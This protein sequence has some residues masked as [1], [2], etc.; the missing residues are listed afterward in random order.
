MVILLHCS[1]LLILETYFKII[2]ERSEINNIF[3]LVGHRH[4]TFNNNQVQYNF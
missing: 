3:D 4:L 1:Y 2:F